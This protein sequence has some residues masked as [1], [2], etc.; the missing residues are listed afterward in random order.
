MPCLQC[1][2]HFQHYA[3]GK[4]GY[5]DYILRMPTWK[6][7]IPRLVECFLFHGLDVVIR[8]DKERFETGLKYVTYWGT[9]EQQNCHLQNINQ[10]NWAGNM[11]GCVFLDIVG[12]VF[13]ISYYVV[14]AVNRLAWYLLVIFLRGR[15]FFL[16][17]ILNVVHF[18]CI[19]NWWFD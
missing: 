19:S 10:T 14:A 11:R 2:R 4:L 13:E 17:Q 15:G 6:N 18:N 8:F 1:G 3:C 9:L 16:V 7:L 5:F 12:S